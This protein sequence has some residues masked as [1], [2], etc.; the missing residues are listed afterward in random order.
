[1]SLHCV[2]S[3]RCIG[4]VASLGC[5][6]TDGGLERAF[7]VRRAL[8]FDTDRH[9]GMESEAPALWFDV[10]SFAAANWLFSGKRTTG[11]R[12]GDDDSRSKNQRH[13]A[14]N[15]KRAVNDSRCRGNL[16][17]RAPAFKVPRMSV[18]TRQT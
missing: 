17:Q 13:E 2:C 3:L 8:I 1:M 15:V 14:G 9:S 12:S 16:V 5:L 7:S 6:V 18:T 10:D 11:R 4:T